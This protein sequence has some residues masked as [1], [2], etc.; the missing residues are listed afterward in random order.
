MASTVEP[1]TDL[2]I[3]RLTL[4]RPIADV[5][6]DLGLDPDELELYGNDKA[7]IPLSALDR[8]RDVS[9]GTL[10][11]VTGITP[12]P[13]GEGKTTT[14]IGLADGLARSG[15]SAVVCLREPSMGPVFGIKG[16]GAG[17]GRSQVVPMED[18]NL[19]FTG[20]IHA[21]AAATNLLAAMI[22]AHLFHGNELGLDPATITWRRALDVNDRALRRIVTGLGPSGGVAQ[23]TG[24]DITAAS[25]T[26]G[27][28][29]T[30]RDLLELRVR[31]GKITIGRTLDGAPVTAEALGA[32]GAMAVLL[33]DALEPNLIQ[34]L[35]GVPAIV[36]AGPFA[37]IA[38]GNNSLVAD[39]LA[40][41][42]AEYVVTEGGFGSDMGFEKHVNLVC[43]RAGFH[44]SAVVLVATL[45]ALRHH[46]AG[47]LVTG[48]AN[49]ER[50][51][52][53][54]R[55]FGIDPVV[56]VNRFPE[57]SDADVELVRA[58]AMERGAFAAE[59]T[60]AYSDG[61]AGAAALA[62]AVAAAAER[63]SR[64]HFSYDLQDPIPVKIEKLARKVYGAAGIELSAEARET[65]AE[66][67]AE[68]LARLPIC[69]AKTPLSLSHD[70][71]L[72]NAPRD[73]TLPVR[74]IRPY[75]GA[76]WLV[77]LCGDLMTMPG[78][79]ARPAA[80]DID[81]DEHGRTVGLR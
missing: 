46:G 27:I 33:K 59:S 69:M 55:G 81:I 53:I 41:V 20:D 75:T 74:E 21:V 1:L 63:P 30:A 28:L 24:F 54:V 39:L 13:L 36:H 50:H 4:V 12:T 22:D 62:E 38:H 56:A 40:L 67:E 10:I 79:S 71:A 73:F 60:S 17:G 51:I 35:E 32:A 57:D 64:L 14:A 42:T 8:R 47:D 6:A 19:H 45:R 76:G 2:E 70:P 26:M 66:C 68:G 25:E 52:E 23:G 31:L 7:K 29:A 16:G 65:I 43:R 3:A 49:L 34:T 61:G 58:L 48:A 72:V 77:V 11:A 37:N 18:L 5:A 9:P 80:L 44:P 78:L 15:R